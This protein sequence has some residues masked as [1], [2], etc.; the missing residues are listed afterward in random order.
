MKRGMHDQISKFSKLLLSAVTEFW[1][2]E[3]LTGRH[4]IMK[5][6]GGQ[7]ALWNY[8]IWDRK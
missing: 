8:Q 5:E 7:E 3:F 6:A 2:W 1:E 4:E